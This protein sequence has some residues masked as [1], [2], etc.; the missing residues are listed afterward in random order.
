MDLL[1]NGVTM[2]VII[3]VAILVLFL[4]VFITKYKTVG[5]DEALIV[6]GSYLE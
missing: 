5:P 1:T 2:I 3:A 6:S 4:I